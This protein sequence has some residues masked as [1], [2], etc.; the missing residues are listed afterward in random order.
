MYLF[1]GKYETKLFWASSNP[2]KIYS[3]ESFFKFLL[4]KYMYVLILLFLFLQMSSHF[5]EHD[6]LH[7]SSKESELSLP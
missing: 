2:K 6:L 1:S 4:M 5:L 3:V 7:S